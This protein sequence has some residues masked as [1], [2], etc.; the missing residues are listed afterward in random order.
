MKKERRKEFFVAVT[1]EKS[2]SL[3]YNFNI[4]GLYI[5]INTMLNTQTLN[6]L[7]PR[8]KEE[9]SVLSNHQ[10]FMVNHSALATTPTANRLPSPLQ[11]Y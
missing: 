4:M 3:V 10:R 11:I 6:I 5:W 8:H 7:C 9:V 1:L 2:I